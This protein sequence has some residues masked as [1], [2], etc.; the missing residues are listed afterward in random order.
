MEEKEM[1]LFSQVE[2]LR[3]QHALDEEQWKARVKDLTAVLEAKQ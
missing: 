2:D 1:R 3:S